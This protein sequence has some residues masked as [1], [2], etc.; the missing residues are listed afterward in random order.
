MESPNVAMDTIEIRDADSAFKYTF[1][2]IDML[3]NYVF[4]ISMK[5]IC[6]KNTST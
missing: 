5:D 3:T 1:K 2:L 6:W 4:V